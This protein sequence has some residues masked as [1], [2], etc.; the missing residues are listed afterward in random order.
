LYSKLLGTAGNYIAHKATVAA[1][2]NL[3]IVVTGA[4]TAGNPYVI[5]IQ[6]ANTTLTKNTATLVKAAI[7]AKAEA[8]ALVADVLTGTGAGQV[9]VYAQTSL[10][11][12]LNGTTGYLGQEVFDTDGVLWK[13]RRVSG[14]Y[15]YW[16][17]AD[18]VFKAYNTEYFAYYDPKLGKNVY[19]VNMDTYGNLPGSTIKSVLHLRQATSIV[20]FEA[21]QGTTTRLPVNGSYV[22]G[23]TYIRFICSP[24]A[25]T[26]QTGYDASGTTCTDFIIYYT[27]D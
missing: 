5:D 7:E 17:T 4:G 22:G 9:A 15:Y 26:C 25:M 18:A 6:L 20:A 16:T 19:R 10:S 12:G 27:K 2:D 21:R 8:N 11:G 24:T 13:L 3:A 14:D 1:D 23:S